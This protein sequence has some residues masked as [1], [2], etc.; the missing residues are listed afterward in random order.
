MKIVTINGKKCA[1]VRYENSERPNWQ[2]INGIMSQMEKPFLYEM[3]YP[4]E[5]EIL[6]TEDRLED[7]GDYAVYVFYDL[8]V[9]A[10]EL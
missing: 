8:V 7:K 9:R 6:I 10:M 3:M 2:V 4:G 5:Y 1:I